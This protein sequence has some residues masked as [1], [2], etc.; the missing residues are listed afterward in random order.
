MIPVDLKY[1]TGHEWLRIDGETATIGIT[2][3]AQSQLGDIT[4]VE[5]PAIGKKFQAT[6]SLAVVESVKAAS[7]VY[8]P[9]SGTVSEINEDLEATPESINSDPYTTGWICKLSGVATADI[10]SAMS[11]E[12][13]ETFL[14]E[15]DA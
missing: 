11:A 8:T 6:D 2:D 15:G 4:Y 1:T 12:D 10:D 14:K 3:Y 9:V 5:L 7:D 13:Y